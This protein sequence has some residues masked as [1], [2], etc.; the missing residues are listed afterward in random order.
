MSHKLQKRGIEPGASRDFFC[1]QWQTWGMSKT[2]DI[3]GDDDDED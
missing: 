2:P 1:N 3:D